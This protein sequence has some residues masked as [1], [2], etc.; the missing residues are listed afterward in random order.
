MML[1]MT[2]SVRRIARAAI[3][4]L[5]AAVATLVAGPATP[6]HAAT[7]WYHGDDMEIHGGYA[8]PAARFFFE[9]S[10]GYSMGSMK[11]DAPTETL[12]IKA[13][14]GSYYADL[15]AGYG[16]A[17]GSVGQNVYITPV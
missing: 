12:P 4:L 8:P 17:W 9:T 6:A 2:A 16:T 13:H 10:D 14:S 3:A 11:N 15:G 7:G 5:A 1:R